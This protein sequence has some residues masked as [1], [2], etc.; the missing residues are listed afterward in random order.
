MAPLAVYTRPDRQA[1]RGR[2]LR[3]SLVKDVALAQ[4]LAVVQPESWDRVACEALAARQTDLAVVVAYGS[5]LPEAVLRIPRLGGVNLHLS[6]LPKWRGAAPVARALEAGDQTTGVCLIKLAKELDSGDIVVRR[7]CPIEAHDTAKSLDTKLARLGAQM[8]VPFLGDAES[9]LAAAVPQSDDGVCYAHKLHKREAEID[10]AAVGCRDRPQSAG[11]EPVGRS[12]R[13][14]LHGVPLRI[15]Q[16][17]ICGAP[18]DE[19]DAPGT[20]HIDD[21]RLIVSCGRGAIE[22]KQLQAPGK[23]VMSAQAFLNGHDL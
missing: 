21:K 1:G 8:L 16:S 10:W 22:I 20:V 5:I 3:T 17:E 15:W 11:L 14:P 4:G 13:R 9:M 2:R 12:H 7:E 18:P 6:L 23:K 19:T